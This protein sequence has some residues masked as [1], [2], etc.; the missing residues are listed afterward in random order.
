MTYTITD[1]QG[2]LSNKKTVNTRS[3]PIYVMIALIFT[4]LLNVWLAVLLLMVAH[5]QSLV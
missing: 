3:M 4:G 5:L 2:Q 1:Q